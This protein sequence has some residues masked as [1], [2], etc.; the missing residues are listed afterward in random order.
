[1]SFA[2]REVQRTITIWVGGSD[3]RAVFDQQAQH[4]DVAVLRS[5]VQR[6]PAISVPRID[7]RTCF[8][9]AQYDSSVP[10]TDRDLKRGPSVAI[11]GV[12]VGTFFEERTDRRHVIQS[13]RPQKVSG[14][15]CLRSGGGSRHEHHHARERGADE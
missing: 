9:E 2:R 15:H 1:M 10:V 5:M 8:E 11:E 13:H 4:I 12:R 14:S 6:S 7:T 3:I